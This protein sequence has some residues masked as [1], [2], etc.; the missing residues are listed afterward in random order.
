MTLTLGHF[1][2]L[3]AIVGGSRTKLIPSGK[4]SSSYY[5][6]RERQK[7]LG[8]AVLCDTGQRLDPH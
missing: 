6:S 4:I 1:L 3:G 8:Q 7:A 5:Y 2:T